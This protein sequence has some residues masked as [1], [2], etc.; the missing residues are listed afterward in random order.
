VTD[1]TMFTFEQNRS[2]R[3]LQVELLV[4]VLRKAESRVTLLT[5][6]KGVDEVEAQAATAMHFVWVLRD[7]FTHE[8]DEAAKSKAW[9][10]LVT[11]WVQILGL[12]EW[13][14]DH[15][16]WRHPDGYKGDPGYIVHPNQNTLGWTQKALRLRGTGWSVPP[17]DEVIKALVRARRVMNTE[18]DAFVQTPRRLVLIECKDE[19]GFTTEQ[20]SRQQALA[21]AL[22]RLLPRPEPPVF[23]EGISASSGV[24]MDLG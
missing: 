14:Q 10:S 2:E 17:M 9:S 1:P 22:S 6:I 15:R 21:K 16:W 12:P 24:S 5:T 13:A 8:R 18:C 4:P 7:Q 19:T 3:A 20:Q 23:V 11:R